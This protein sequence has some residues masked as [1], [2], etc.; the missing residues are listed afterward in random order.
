MYD[1]SISHIDCH[2]TTIADQVTRLCICIGNFCSCILL[3]VGS[4]RK[5]YAKV[6]I[7]TLHETGT[8]STI[9]KTCTTPDIG[10]SNKLCR[11]INYRRS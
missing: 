2:M 1:L 8:V 7:Y 10:I 5:A 6:C 4:S 11:I 9:G 3:F